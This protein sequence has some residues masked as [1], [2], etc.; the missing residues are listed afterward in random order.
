MLRARRDEFEG[1]RIHRKAFILMHDRCRLSWFLSLV[2]QD[3]MSRNAI[4]VSSDILHVSRLAASC[5][6]ECPEG[7]H[8]CVKDGDE[9][10]A[11]SHAFDS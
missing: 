5:I 3:F 9:V 7:M 11:W 4:Y 10:S 8:C 6:L 1:K 2:L